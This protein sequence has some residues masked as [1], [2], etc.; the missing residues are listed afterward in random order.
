MP[1]L[2][3]SKGP[4]SPFGR[5][6]YPLSGR[7]VGKTLDYREIGSPVDGIRFGKFHNAAQ[8]LQRMP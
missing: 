6:Q 3:W 4:I 7:P 2:E 1:H 5:A 8:G